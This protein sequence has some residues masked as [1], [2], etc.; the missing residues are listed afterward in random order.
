MSL[1]FPYLITDWLTLRKPELAGSPIVFALPERGK[2][3]I[4][5]VNLVA[6]K[7]G[8]KA[9]TLLADAKA[10]VTGLQVFNDKQERETKLL[11]ALGEWSIIYTPIIAIDPPNG[12]T[13]NIS[14]CTHL[15]GGEHNY[16]TEVTSRLKSKGYVVKAAIASTIGA[17]WANARF[18]QQNKIIAPRQ[19]RA[20]ILHLPPAALR[21]DGIVL[22]RLHK[23]GLTAVHTFID[24]PR[25]NLRRRFGEG[26][27]LRLDQALGI[28]TERLQ[29]LQPQQPYQERLPC[30][31]PIYT[32][33]GIE[34]AIE[35]LLAMLCQRLEQ[36]G[37][38]VRAATLKCYRVDG[39]IEQV[40]IGT[41]KASHQAAHLMT[42]F[43][44]Q[45]PSIEPAFGIE[46]FV[47]DVTEAEKVEVQQEHLWIERSGLNDNGVAELLDRISG[48]LG[49][50]RVHR[51]LPQQHHWPEWS[52]K[53]TVSLLEVPVNNWPTDK[54]RPTQLLL[55]PQ[56]IEV[57]APIPDDP[58]MLFRY[59]NIVHYI[60]KADGPERIEREWWLNQGEHRDYYVVEDD[61]G[62]RYWLFRSGH[63]AA[64]PHQWFLH[65]FFA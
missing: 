45:I 7:Q 46:L 14:G 4:S 5:A 26:L 61:A 64:A 19:E 32:V 34:I 41:R 65:G 17:A 22:D 28:R 35:Q 30:L 13:F 15:W 10:I 43:E 3:I 48:K 56:P 49:A 52:V 11:T 20:A 59:Q 38:G 12:L 39:K 31:E 2:M 1:C 54:P 23:L 55:R 16:I 24:I 21:L 60:K 36:E 40:N 62:R 29:P 9:G 42:L 27:Q 37:K 63:Y 6:A 8:I 25:S 58:P 47:M 50:K 33:I 53:S 51:Y 57:S 44:L 18:G